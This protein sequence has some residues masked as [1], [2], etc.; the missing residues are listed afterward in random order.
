MDDPVRRSSLPATTVQLLGD[1]HA[2]FRTLVEQAA[3]AIFVRDREGRYLYVNRAAA[4]HL[5]CDPADVVGKTVD[6]LFPPHSAAEFKAAGARVIDSG[7]TLATEHLLDPEGERTWIGTVLQ[8]LR[9]ATGCIVAAHGVV[10]VITVQKAAEQAM[11]ESEQRLRQA[12]GVAHIGIFEH[13]HIHDTLYLSPE[14]LEILG[15]D[16]TPE[17]IAGRSALATLGRMLDG[18]HPDDKARVVAALARSHDPA[19]DGVH[20]IEHRHVRPDGNVRVVAVRSQT[21]FDGTGAARRPVRGVGAVRDVTEWRVVE[22]AQRGLEAQLNQAQKMESVGRFAGGVAHDFNNMLSVI[23]GWSDT[24][25]AELN[26]AHPVFEALS[27]IRTAAKRSID[28]TSQLLAFARSQRIAPKVL[29]LNNEIAGA[30]RMVERIVG[31]N[32]RIEW[33]PGDAL[34]PVHI[35]PSQVAQT[36]TNLVANARDAIAGTGRVTITTS[37]VTVSGAD[38]PHP[39]EPGEYVRLDVADDGAGMD[40]DTRRHIFEPFYTTK[41]EGRGTGLG[42]ATVYGIVKQNGGWIDVASAPALGTTVSIL[43]RRHEGAIDAPSAVATPASTRG[44]ETILVVDDERMVLDLTSRVLAREGYTMLAANSPE[45]ALA[46]AAAHVGPIHLLVTDVV[47]PTMNGVDLAARL[48]A[49]RP[50][51]KRLYVSGH[52]FG[53]LAASDSPLLQKP[54]APA[55]LVATVRVVL[56]DPRGRKQSGTD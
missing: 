36:L 41:P 1:D 27:E 31:E 46:I 44:D 25:L 28:L 39:F 14:L 2:L 12:V 47:M 4:A 23:L 32:V 26:A 9:D 54:F 49:Q 7:E 22:Q 24:A 43:L 5:G 50:H 11:R 35:D 20:E 6:E 56:D 16:D 45:A 38:R 52:H 55:T 17:T 29:N 33:R 18:V 42:L 51:L 3:E 48:V 30:L 10:R 13:D 19:G 15:F 8:P 40:D 37:N 34:W 21:F 53:A